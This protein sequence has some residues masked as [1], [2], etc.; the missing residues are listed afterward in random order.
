MLKKLSTRLTARGSLHLLCMKSL[1]QIT[2]WRYL[3][4]DGMSIRI[5][6]IVFI[7]KDATSGTIR[8]RPICRLKRCT[9]PIILQGLYLR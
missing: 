2:G 3:K 8:P 7:K 6:I 1:M 4:K 9:I 5:W